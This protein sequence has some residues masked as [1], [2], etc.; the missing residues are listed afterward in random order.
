MR[1]ASII[2]L[3]AVVAAIAWY[4]H[5]TVL[6][7]PPSAPGAQTSTQNETAALTEQP[8]LTDDKPAQTLETEAEHFIEALTETDA[9]PVSADHADHFV[10]AD[11]AIS[12]LP[13][14]TI[15]ASSLAEVLADPH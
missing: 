11:Q 7:P 15:E 8:T 4:F 13:P 12:L 9:E 2:V 5:G 3:L 1:A 14:G 10:R 6:P